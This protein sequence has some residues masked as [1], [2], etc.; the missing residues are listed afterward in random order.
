[1][2]GVIV[3]GKHLNGERSQDMASTLT[4]TSARE[5]AKKF[6]QFLFSFKLDC[7]MS[8]SLA[9]SRHAWKA[10]TP[11]RHELIIHQPRV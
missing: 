9:Q 2:V 5:I 11:N 7:L 10:R 6:I 8:M 3:V 4:A 1:M